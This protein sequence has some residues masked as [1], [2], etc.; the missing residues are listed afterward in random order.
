MIDPPPTRTDFPTIDAYEI[1]DV[2]TSDEPPKTRDEFPTVG[3]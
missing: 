1:P 2:E 3:E